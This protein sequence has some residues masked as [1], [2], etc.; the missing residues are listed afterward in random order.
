MLI[1][2]LYKVGQLHFT[3]DLVFDLVI[4]DKFCTKISLLSV[5]NLYN[6]S[7]IVKCVNMIFFL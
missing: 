4:S 1:M 3:W 2:L 7:Y 5:D 6:E